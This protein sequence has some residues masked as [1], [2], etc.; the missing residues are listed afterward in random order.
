MYLIIVIFIF[1]TVMVPLLSIILGQINYLK[2]S[3]AK[4]QALQIAEA[5]V[6]Y[7][8]W[9]LAHFTSDYKDGT[10]NAGPYVHTYT[11]RDTQNIIGSY[12]LVIIPPSVGST[13]VTIQSTGYTSAY[14]NIKRTVTVRYGVASLAKYAFLS[15]DV[16]WIG[17]TENVFG[18]MHSN[19]G[20]RFDGIGNAPI[21]SAKS[22]YSCSSTQGLPCPATENGV[23]GSAP[24]Y[25]QNFWQFPVPAVD[26]SSL[27]ADLSSLK[28]LAQSGGIYLPPSNKEGYSL[29]FK[30][31]GTIDIYKVKNLNNSNNSHGQDTNGK[32]RS[33]AT[34]YKSR[35]FQFNKPMPANGTIFVEDKTWV[36]GTVKGRATVVSGILP[37]SESKNINIYIPNNIL[38]STKNGSDVLGLFSQKDIV[39]SF[40]S[41]KDLE[42]DAAMITQYGSAQFFFY[43]GVVKNNIRIYGSLMSFGQWTWSWVN[44]SGYYVAGYPNSYFV[45]DGNLLYGP[46]PSFPLS[47]SDYQQIDW[48]SN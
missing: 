44:G 36:E 30:S 46:P 2:S 47:S 35:D 33:E 18:L 20:I 5:G 34:D 13:I 41:P 45:Y 4:E 39:V 28:S 11:D 14:P 9:H 8:Q 6:N 31:N 21:T 29:E 7:Y 17:S 23:W 16:I 27:T 43:N 19:N 38:Y 10:N 3:V 40:K 48:K 24:Q 25:V 26:F 37:Y 42:I 1:S 22:T 15:N 12:S 32:D